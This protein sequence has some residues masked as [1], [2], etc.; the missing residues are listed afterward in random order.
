L[1]PPVVVVPGADAV[2][3]VGV[4]NAFGWS[5][6]AHREVAVRLIGLLEVVAVSAAPVGE[7]GELLARQE[8]AE[9]AASVTSQ[10]FWVNAAKAIREA[11]AQFGL[12]VVW[13]AVAAAPAL[14]EG[15]PLPLGPPAWWICTKDHAAQLLPTSSL[16]RSWGLKELT[17]SLQP[18]R[19]F[20]V[21]EEAEAREDASG[22]DVD[23]DRDDR[24]PRRRR[25]ASPVRDAHDDPD[26]FTIA[27][28]FSDKP[29]PGTVRE[30]TLHGV[31]GTFVMTSS[32]T[33]VGTPVPWPS[34]GKAS[35]TLALSRKDLAGFDRAP[36]ALEAMVLALRLGL[37]LA[38]AQDPKFIAG[39][40]RMRSRWPASLGRTPPVQVL[41]S[42]FTSS[43]PSYVDICADVGR[44]LSVAEVRDVLAALLHMTRGWVLPG[45]PLYNALSTVSVHFVR[46]SET[47]V[48]TTAPLGGTE[49]L[50][51]A[52][53]WRAWDS[54][55]KSAHM[56][57]ERSLDESWAEGVEDALA[58]G[59]DV[60]R[61]KWCSTFQL[62]VKRQSSIQLHDKITAA[63]SLWLNVVNVAPGAA[64]L[65]LSLP[66][67]GP[68]SGGSAG[69]PPP[70]PGGASGPVRQC[71]GWSRTG[72]CSFGRGCRF[73]EGHTP[74]LASSLP[75]PDKRKQP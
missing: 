5:S 20:V 48:L 60:D 11:V 39:L 71:P 38:S 45:D 58:S 27:A 8:L 34:M 47:Y 55:V 46:F 66:S 54:A 43:L 28:M 36:T 35:A 12:R 26:A 52:A 16:R 15:A 1:L 4:V 24:P 56:A 67:A 51:L 53:W 74:Q 14:A 49:A 59:T 32:Y 72:K 44:P 13:A 33:G 22:S 2:R 29:L 63:M 21:D 40:L 69:G 75:C 17:A 41:Q 10:P 37:R 42:L 61:V 6:R 50:A 68:P 25:V 64:G 70:A 62:E 30:G 3:P 23:R 7:A 73:V 9:L 31:K 65:R 19:V 18:A 57:M